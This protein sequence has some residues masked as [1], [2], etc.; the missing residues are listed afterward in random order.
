MYCSAYKVMPTVALAGMTASLSQI[1][2]LQSCYNVLV[3]VCVQCLCN[4]WFSLLRPEGS[5]LVC[6]IWLPVTALQAA[7]FSISICAGC[8]MIKC[9]APALVP[10]IILC[11]L[12]KAAPI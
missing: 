12:E 5:R 1:K 9:M 8:K 2:H 10:L 3:K 7:S 6:I 4:T 11:L